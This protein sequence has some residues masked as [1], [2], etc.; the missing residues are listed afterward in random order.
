MATVTWSYSGSGAYRGDNWNSITLTPAGALPSDAIITDIRFSIEA[1]Y[2][3]TA[4]SSSSTFFKFYGIAIDNG[5]YIASNFGGS[6]PTT[7]LIDKVF[8]VATATTD[9]SFDTTTKKYTGYNEGEARVWRQ[10]N[11]TYCRMYNSKFDNQTVTSAFYDSELNIKVLFYTNPSNYTTYLS[12][13]EVTVTYILPTL[14]AP[15]APVI[16]QHDTNGTYSVSWTPAIGSYGTGEIEYYLYR[17]NY[18]NILST[19]ATSLGGINIPEYGDQT[20]FVRAKYSEKYFSESERSSIVFYPPSVIGPEYVSITPTSGDS[21]TLEWSE[22]TLKWTDGDIR[23][24]IW[25]KT[26]D[27]T[28]GQESVLQGYTM[29]TNRSFYI[30]SD[31]LQARV[32]EDNKVSFRIVSYVYDL[33]N[34]IENKENIQYQSELSEYFTY[35]AS[36]TIGYYENG[37]WQEC[38]VY[39][40]D[41]SEWVEC[42]PYY[43]DSNQPQPWV[44]IKTK[45]T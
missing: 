37:K 16:T 32:G 43:Y 6:K 42:I 19:T 27:K 13:I 45:L 18:E 17:N 1:Y 8:K 4:A 40:Y 14:T 22:P 24:G 34:N 25:Y 21:V 12:N 41:G 35:E 3:A 11:R 26:K 39:Y 38:I 9:N 15:G 30:N 44:P 29:T 20:F 36:Y 7:A 10:S 5:P 2:G 31:W 33:T 23:Y 28:T